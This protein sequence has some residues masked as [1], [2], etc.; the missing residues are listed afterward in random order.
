M[1]GWRVDDFDPID[2]IVV[3]EDNKS[4]CF[5]SNDAGFLRDGRNPYTGN[6]IPN[7]ILKIIG[8][9]ITGD[10]YEEESDDEG[11]IELVLT[12][13]ASISIYPTPALRHCLS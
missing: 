12:R 13:K 4:Y 1:A 7:D 6:L 11:N 8:V 3:S 2:K 5:T 10:V 9:S